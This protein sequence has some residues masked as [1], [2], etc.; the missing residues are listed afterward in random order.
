MKKDTLKQE[1]RYAIHDDIN[2]CSDGYLQI[3]I[4][5][6]KVPQNKTTKWLFWNV[7]WTIWKV[8]RHKLLAFVFGKL[9]NVC[10]KISSITNG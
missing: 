9:A 4:T 10:E 1:E 5:P 2:R 7:Y 8:W 6:L 3:T